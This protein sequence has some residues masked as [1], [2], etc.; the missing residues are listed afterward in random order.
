[1]KNSVALT[2]SNTDMIVNFAVNYGGRNE[3]VHA[4]K[5]YLKEGPH[6]LSEEEFER[7]LYTSGCPSPELIIRTSGE[8]R[9][10]G[11]LLW[12][13]AHEFQCRKQKA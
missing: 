12:Q 5:T 9:L 10:S 11:F 1:M 4:M 2:K 8:K 7:F 3:I 6:E 13:S